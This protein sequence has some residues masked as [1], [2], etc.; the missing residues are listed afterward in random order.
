MGVMDSLRELYTVA[1][2][3]GRAPRKGDVVTVVEK[4]D[5]YGTGH[6]V[7]IDGL[8]PTPWEDWPAVVQLDDGSTEL[9]LLRELAPVNVEQFER[10]AG[11]S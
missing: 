6:V 11:G 5:F 4:E 9:F 3:E 2:Q 8:G 7:K 10:A 1:C